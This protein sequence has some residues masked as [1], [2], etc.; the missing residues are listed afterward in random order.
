MKSPSADYVLV[1]RP[2][3]ALDLS[4]I[5]LG[6]ELGTG[7][8]DWVFLALSLTKNPS[9]QVPMVVWLKACTKAR[10]WL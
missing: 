3:W 7:F 5:E 1:S 2:S 8:F 6:R 4:D 9:R 10:K